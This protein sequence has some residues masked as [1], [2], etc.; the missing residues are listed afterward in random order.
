MRDPKI[1]SEDSQNPDFRSTRKL[2]KG[3]FLN[4]QGLIKLE[5]LQPRQQQ[6]PRNQ[7]TETTNFVFAYHSAIFL[8]RELPPPTTV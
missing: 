5:K 3:L 6:Q 7:P 2:E 1:T 4:Q 8:G